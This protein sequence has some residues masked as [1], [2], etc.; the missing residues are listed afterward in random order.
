MTNSVLNY[1]PWLA[2]C[3]VWGDRVRSDHVLHADL[4]A[5]QSDTFGCVLSAGGE[6]ALYAD[7][8]RVH[9]GVLIPCTLDGVDTRFGVRWNKD[10]HGTFKR[11]HRALISRAHDALGVLA[12]FGFTRLSVHAHYILVT[13]ATPWPRGWANAYGVKQGEKVPSVVSTLPDVL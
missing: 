1:R 3:G 6:K 9:D 12:G 7:T 10:N 5:W 2:G 8:W 4:Y 13:D 11:V